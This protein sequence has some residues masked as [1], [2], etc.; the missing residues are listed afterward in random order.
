[1]NLNWLSLSEFFE[2][3]IQIGLLYHELFHECSLVVSVKNLYYNLRH[4]QSFSRG[5]DVTKLA[6]V[7]TMTFLKK[8][9]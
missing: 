1:M 9:I 2:H 5:K 7:V 8:S 4:A 3:L 6:K